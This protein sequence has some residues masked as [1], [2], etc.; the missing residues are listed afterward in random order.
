MCR[1]SKAEHL[2]TSQLIGEKSREREESLPCC[3]K[4][5]IRKQNSRKKSDDYRVGS[6]GD[7]LEW[8]KKRKGLGQY[9]VGGEGGR[10]NYWPA[11]SQVER[12]VHNTVLRRLSRS[13]EKGA[14]K[15]TRKKGLL[16][17]AG[18]EG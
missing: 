15:G 4:D 1:A 13:P 14:K 3:L 12:G 8:K 17:K 2:Y 9:W 11:I 6:E 18:S 5:E 10:T 16:I 7:G